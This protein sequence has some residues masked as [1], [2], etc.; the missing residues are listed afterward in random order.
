MFTKYKKMYYEKQESAI[1]RCGYLCK[2][3]FPNTDCIAQCIEMSYNSKL[4]QQP[5]NDGLMKKKLTSKKDNYEKNQFKWPKERAKT[6][7]KEIHE[8]SINYN[9]KL[10][11]LQPKKHIVPENVLEEA[12]QEHKKIYEENKTKMPPELLKT[13]PDY[14]YLVHNYMDQMNKIPKTEQSIQQDTFMKNK[15]RQQQIFSGGFRKKF[16]NSNRTNRSK[17]TNKS[18]RTKRTNKSKRTKRTNKSKRTKRTKRTNKS[19][20]TKRTNKSNR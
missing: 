11:K 5:L 6:E 9:N 4:L 13:I 19:K 1:D 14:S 3:K 20:R 16:N 10:P 18:K 17:R 2:D 12:L 15:V 7:R 8:L